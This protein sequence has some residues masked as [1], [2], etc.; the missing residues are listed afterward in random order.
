MR[1][2]QNNNQYREIKYVKL[3][4]ARI[5]KKNFTGKYVPPYNPE[6]SRN[7][8]VELPEDVAEQM[9]ADGWKVKHSKPNEN[10]DGDGIYYIMVQVGY[11]YKPPTI[12]RICKDSVKFLDERNVSILDRDRIISSKMVIRSRYWGE[13]KDKIKAYLQELKVEVMPNDI[14]D[15]MDYEEET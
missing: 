5:F 10:Y 6:G 8:L 11:A 1:N 12:Q 4:D 9:M 13:N 7:F 14:S 2:E 15:F 3:T